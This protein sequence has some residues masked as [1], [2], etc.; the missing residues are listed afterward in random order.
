MTLRREILDILE[1]APN[2]LCD[3]CLLR[4]TS[5]KQRP[6]VNTICRILSDEGRLV[7]GK[8][9]LDCEH[10]HKVITPN[11]LRPVPGKSSNRSDQASSA[12]AINDLDKL[13]R[14]VIQFL[15]KLDHGTSKEG[16]SRRVA[17]LRNNQ[18]LPSRIAALMLTHASYRNDV[19]YNG[20]VLTDDECRIVDSIEKCLRAYI[21]TY[22]PD[23]QIAN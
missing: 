22:K 2:G 6:Q 17:M 18:V 15:N 3:G 9:G 20:Y 21:D 23:A 8:S 10:C 13:R 19:Y 11:S 4:A 5:A 7:R 1:D 16:F 14:E 12:L